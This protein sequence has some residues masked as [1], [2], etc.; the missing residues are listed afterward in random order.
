MNVFRICDWRFSEYFQGFPS[1]NFSDCL[2]FSAVDKYLLG[3]KDLLVVE[4]IVMNHGED[5]FESNFF[6]TI[7]PGL[8]YK[9]VDKK[10]DLRDTTITCTAPN[11]DNNNV[12]KCDLGNPFPGGK[13]AKFNVILNPAQKAGMAPS[14]DFYMEA[15]S[16]NAEREGSGLDNIYKKTISIWVET[17]LV[18]K[19]NSYPQEFHY[20]LT[21]YK[22]IENATTEQEIGPQVVHIYDISNFGPSTI[23]EAEIYVIWPYETQEG[24]DLMYLLS[25]PE[26]SGNI[27]CENHVQ[28][29]SRRLTIDAMLEKKG[30]LEE[31]TGVVSKNA[32]GFAKKQEGGQVSKVAI[33]RTSSSSGG[34]FGS[35]SSSSSSSSSGS[36]V[37]SEKRLTEEE[38]RRLDAEENIESTGDASLVHRSRNQGQHEVGGA[39]SGNLQ[40]SS[41]WSTSSQG[42]SPVTFTRSQNRTTFTG[43]DGRSRTVESS[44]EYS[45]VNAASFGGASSGSY[46]QSQG[47]QGSRQGMYKIPDIQTE[48]VI[49]HDLSSSAG[50]RSSSSAAGSRIT[51]VNTIET[52]TKASGRRRM[53]SQGDGESVR[54]GGYSGTSQMEKVAQGG[55]GFQSATMDL[56]VNRGNVDDDLHRRG[57]GS[58][59][60][61]GGGY[62]G[63]ARSGSSGGHRSSSSTFQTSQS[64][65]G[66]SSGGHSTGKFQYGS[67]PT[68]HHSSSSGST[69]GG[70]HVAT[71]TY[72]DN[73]GDDDY[74]FDNYDYDANDNSHGSSASNQQQHHQQS[75]SHSSSS[76]GGQQQHGHD[77]KLQHYRRFKRSTVPVTEDDH[78]LMQELNQCNATKCAI[79]KC[80]A[81][82]LVHDDRAFIGLRTRL[83]AYTLDKN[84]LSVP[85]NISSKVVARIVKLPYI[86]E[87]QE[88]PLKTFEVPV[89]AIPEPIVTPDVVPLWV[90][91]LSAVAGALILLLLILLLYKV[92]GWGRR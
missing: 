50:S 17:D 8:N 74:S 77:G 60:T 32:Q 79:L 58:M 49:N 3:S 21:Q 62:S 51:N 81:G 89:K 61:G 66:G 2:S 69:H 5:A 90:V 43:A 19:G 23:E 65:G 26:T 52:T 33:D 64:G 78:A 40:Q 9:R 88:K 92:S 57:G 6:M 91:I 10:G 83:V 84:T 54:T 29:N 70:H 11:R 46:R 68:Q 28:I 35:S 12:L 39:Y 67:N 24:D 25:R 16:T 36:R 80:Y 71:T 27:R 47:S 73:E 82:P 13:V 76:A 31:F 7:P 44:T 15:N 86:G 75:S 34:S 85:L 14:Y 22:P 59:T 48:E 87:P 63:S 41:S 56:G 72:D 55:H 53:M 20:N 42:S 18:I 45:T 4:V 1:S 38:K 37:H 30:V